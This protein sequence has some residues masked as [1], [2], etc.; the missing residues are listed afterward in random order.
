MQGSNINTL[1]HPSGWVSL[2]VQNYFLIH[3]AFWSKRHPPSKFWSV[4]CPQSE[5]LSK[6][7]KYTCRRKFPHICFIFLIPNVSLHN[8]QSNFNKYFLRLSDK[9]GWI[10]NQEQ[11]CQGRNKGERRLKVAVKA[12]VSHPQ[13][14][15]CMLT[16]CHGFC[17]ILFHLLPEWLW[18]PRRACYVPEWFPRSEYWIFSCR[19]SSGFP[20]PCLEILSCTFQITVPVKIFNNL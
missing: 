12:K 9:Q 15:L 4:L 11:E 20:G 17:C 10:Q 5:S 16:V 2:P 13:I 6:R 14:L 19:K 3:D 18:C 1:G 8:H 7:G